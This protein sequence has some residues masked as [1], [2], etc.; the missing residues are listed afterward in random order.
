MAEAAD[1]VK[2]ALEYMTLLLEQ[3]E[4]CGVGAGGG[5]QKEGQEKR[6]TGSAIARRAEDLP[7]LVASAG[8]I[9]A[10]TFYMSKAERDKFRA[11]LGILAGGRAVE[12]CK[13]IGEEFGAGE[14]AGYSAMLAVAAKALEDLGFINVSE[15]LGEGGDPLQTLARG[16]QRLRGSPEEL[17]AERQMI[18][19]LVE[20]KKLAE[21]FFKSREETRT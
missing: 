17:V 9:P 4:K 2:L 5:E 11:F 18:E 19:L 15:S 1:P 3:A 13:G 20:V 8:L 7:S 14:G 6:R 16:L 10:L 21:A 12:E